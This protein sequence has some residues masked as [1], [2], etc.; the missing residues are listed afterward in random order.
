MKRILYFILI[1]CISGVSAIAQHNEIFIPREF[2]KAVE[3]GTRTNKGIP[4][5]QYF[6]NSAIYDMDVYF[7][8]KTALLKGSAE[9][10]YRNNSNDSLK[11]IVMRLYANLFKAEVQRQSDVEVSDLNDGV[12]IK[13]L[14]LDDAPFD[15][16]KIKYNQTN[17]YFP[18]KNKLA[19]LTEMRLE[20]EWEVQMPNKTLI[21]MGRYDTNSYFVAYWYPQIAVYDDI[22]GWNFESY[23]GLQEF[24]NDYAS[25]NVNIT[26]PKGC[27][28]WATGMLQNEN[29]IFSKPV[30][31]RIKNARVSDELVRIITKEDI[32]KQ[33]VL[34]NYDNELTWSFKAD[35]VPDFAFGVSD[36]YIWDGTSV[37]VDSATQRRAMANAVY[38]KNSAAG[39]GVA[40]ITRRT[41]QALSYEIVGYPYPYPHNTVWE[42]HFGMEFP[43]MCNDGPG[44]DLFDEVF[45]TSH[46]VSHSYFPFLVGTN[47]QRYAWIDEGLITFIPKVIEMEYGNENAHYYINS[48]SRYA[49]GTSYDIPLSVP[50]TQ[51]SP[52][53]YM[54]QNYGRAAV[55]FYFLHEALGSEAFRNVLREYV[56][57]WKGKHPTPTDLFYIFEEVSGEDWA[58]YWNKWFYEYGY[59]DLAL[60]NV[61]VKG[62]QLAL[63]VV[64]LGNFPVPIKL[65]VVFEDNSEEQIYQDIR[66]WKKASN[67]HLEK[68]F[69]KKIKEIRLGN[70]NIPDAFVE[71]NSFKV[72]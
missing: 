44:E 63:D 70:K 53:T 23:T 11:F 7:D 54:M 62:G 48:Y 19:P 68:G 9:I 6:Q 31:E 55:G 35:E 41:I 16:S 26:V 40:M 49:M 34:L 12:K 57:R 10:K 47:E 32:E 45:V 43:M 17:M 67:W 21:R 38:H 56:L 58:W 4:G 14:E 64:K 46:E 30:L 72:S 15:L 1:C 13:K 60:K 24:Y 2:R 52:K 29:A 59:A 66:I 5:T 42:G 50:T 20:I 65:F 61:S 25:F 22:E 18:L 36:S 28:V 71:D 39:D 37:M 27:I 3:N 51:M 8:T 33:K 69:D